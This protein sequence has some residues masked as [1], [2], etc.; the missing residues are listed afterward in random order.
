MYWKNKFVK[1]TVH[2]KLKMKV[3]KLDKK[4]TDATTLIHIDQYKTDKH[5]LKKKLNMLIKN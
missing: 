4:S 5:N 2:K 3:N 1:K